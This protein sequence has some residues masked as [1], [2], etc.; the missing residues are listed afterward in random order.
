MFDLEGSGDYFPPINIYAARTA[1]VPTN[2]IRPQHG[3]VDGR[4]RLH[5]RA[6]CDVLGRHGGIGFW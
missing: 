6:D 2:R 4:N 5:A 3:Q 1:K